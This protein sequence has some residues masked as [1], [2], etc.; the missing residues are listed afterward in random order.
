[1]KKV[2]EIINFIG[3]DVPGYL[4]V[5]MPCSCNANIHSKSGLKNKQ[6]H[7][8]CFKNGKFYLQSNVLFNCSSMAK[9]YEKFFFF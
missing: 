7:K 3:K 6:N 5:P 4:S 2:F 8:K 1:M 9:L